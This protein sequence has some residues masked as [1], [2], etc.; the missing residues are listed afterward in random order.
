MT[1][2]VE[3][4]A[5]RFVE[6][7]DLLLGHLHEFLQDLHRWTPVV[8]QRIAVIDEL[9]V[10]ELLRRG[11]VDADDV[12]LQ[13]GAQRV[14]RVAAAFG[15]ARGMDRTGPGGSTLP[16]DA[17]RSAHGGCHPRAHGAAAPTGRGGRAWCE[18][19]P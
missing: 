17:A 14:A 1:Q 16:G 9:G 19:S 15:R 5:A 13:D 12:V 18:S 6:M 8:Q 4:N 11:P 3:I 10:D 7:K 2:E